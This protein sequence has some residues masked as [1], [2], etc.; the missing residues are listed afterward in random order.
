MVIKSRKLSESEKIPELEDEIVD[1]YEK[2]GDELGRI[3]QKKRFQ[4]IDVKFYE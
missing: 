1:W 2:I 4:H 3:G